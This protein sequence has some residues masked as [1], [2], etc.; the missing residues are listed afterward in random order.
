MHT[1]DYNSV[2]KSTDQQTHILIVDDDR[3]IC[4]LVSR[5]LNEHQIRS[6]VAANARDAEHK[7]ANGRFDLMVLDL[8]M[9]GEDGLSFCR[10]MRA[11]SSLPIIMLTAMGEE[12]E[13]I[14]GLEMG[15]DD[16][17]PKPFNPR[18]LLARIRAV[19]RRF[20]SVE[21]V[22]EDQRPRR[23]GFNGWQLDPA[24]RELKDPQGSLITLTSGE[25]DLL[26]AFV[27]HPQRA[28][29]R[30]QLMDLTRGRE[31]LPFDRSIDVQLSRLRQKIEADAKSPQ[32]IKTVRNAGYMFTADVEPFQ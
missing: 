8:M 23:Y 10:R 4:D 1:T 31:A 27:T 15:A 16:Y 29:N 32:L 2:M 14:V 7:L 30:D 11:Q 28:L 9:P 12:T 25:F 26:L 18:E 20:G 6:T 19:L 5:F 13:R 3:E 22:P 17:L 24:R 21:K